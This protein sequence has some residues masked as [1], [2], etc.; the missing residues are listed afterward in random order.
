MHPGHEAAMWGAASPA[1]K[2]SDIVLPVSASSL[3]TAAQM[4]LGFMGALFLGALLLPAL[5]RRGYAQP[6]GSTKEYK[7]TGM[8]LFFV[9]HIAIGAAV[10]GFG[11]SLTPIVRHFWSLFAVANAVAV[12]ITLVL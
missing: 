8:T 5:E 3:T 11:V 9:A 6:D 2:L 1:L 12:A 10:F 4:V 7:L